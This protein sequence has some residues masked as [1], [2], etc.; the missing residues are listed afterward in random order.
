MRILVKSIFLI[1]VLSSH[2]QILSADLDHVTFSQR[3]MG[4]DVKIVL[5]YNKSSHLE[6]AVK[7][8][9][10]EGNRLNLI[11]SDYIADSELSKFSRS[12]NSV[13]SEEIKLSK[14][15]F[16]VLKYCLKLSA[17]SDGSF[18]P[19]L[20]PLTRLWRISRH[21]RLFPE[22]SK[23]ANALARSGAKYLKLDENQQTG[24]LLAPNMILDLGG[25]AKGYIADRML[26]VLQ[27]Y[28]FSRSLV[29]A[30]GDLRIGDAPLESA[31]WKIYIGG[32]KHEKLTMLQLANCAVATSGDT[33]QFLKIKGTQYSHILDPRTGTGLTNQAQATV[34]A[35][36]GME[37]DS[38]ASTFLVTGF[39]KAST[40]INKTNASHLYFLEKHGDHLI[41]NDIHR[42][43][44][45]LQ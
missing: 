31:G 30:G 19:T 45:S 7:E 32:R 28:G 25:V 3:L 44:D 4:T 35:P 20:G 41:F 6:A 13:S 22:Q 2:S 5:N 10:L 43:L 38:L 40:L 23:L 37:A 33:K 34:I 11:F 9:Y 16:E 27:G 26:E 21:Q 24:Q 14:E 39:E 18:D 36:T 1:F 42:N 29:D 8:A 15:L 17:L 12:S